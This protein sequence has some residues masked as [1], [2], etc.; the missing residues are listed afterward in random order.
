MQTNMENDM[1]AGFQVDSTNNQKV[2]MN[3]THEIGSYQGDMIVVQSWSN[4]YLV[5][6]LRDEQW[7]RV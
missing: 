7:F 4:R 6:M 1:E 5:M 2:L 3:P